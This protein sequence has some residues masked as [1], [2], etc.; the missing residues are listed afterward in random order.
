VVGAGGAGAGAGVPGCQPGLHHSGHHHPL[1]FLPHVSYE[2]ALRYSTVTV[3]VR[4]FVLV[5]FV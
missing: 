4:T 3:R 5:C 2:G 1:H